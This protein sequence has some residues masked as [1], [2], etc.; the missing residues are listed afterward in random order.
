[1]DK[2]SSANKKQYAVVILLA[3]IWSLN[4]I[5]MGIVNKEINPFST[6]SMVRFFTLIILTLIIIVKKQHLS[7]VMLNGAMPKLLCIGAL[8][9]LLDLTSFIGFQH[10][11]SSTGTILLK[12]DVVI[13]NILTILIFKQKF[14]KKDWFFTFTMLF[15]VCLVLG[16]NPLSLSFKI[17]DIFF[18]LSAVFVTLNAFLIQHVQKKHNIA[19]HVIAYYNNLL[20]FL[21]F[22]VSMIITNNTFNL[23]KAVNNNGIIM[24]VLAGSITQTLVY[25]LYYKSLAKLPVWIIKV[26]LLL[27]PVFTMLINITLF[28]QLITLTHFIG[29]ILVIVSAAGIIHLHNKST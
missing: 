3:L 18:I 17:Y 14:T 9:F 22:T 16:I 29:T 24:L 4:F 12:T 15:G 13:A 11:D 2:V 10:S 28:K 19:N 7:L 25:M 1:M 20:T 6:G 21:F 8:G 26:I 5:S 27:I 23:F